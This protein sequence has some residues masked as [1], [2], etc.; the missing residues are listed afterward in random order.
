MAEYGITKQ[1]ELCRRT[2]LAKPYVSSLWNGKINL[3]REV[4]E[5]LSQQ[6]GIPLARLM[7]L[8]RVPRQRQRRPGRP[9]KEP[10][11]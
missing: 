6:L 2:G 5:R 11:P 7:T 9:R 3:G 4:G 1:V 8:R 10:P